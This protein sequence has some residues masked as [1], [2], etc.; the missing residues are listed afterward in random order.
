MFVQTEG[1]HWVWAQEA[2]LL[3]GLAQLHTR[4]DGAA[5]AADLL[6]AESAARDAAKS[7]PTISTPDAE[8][9]QDARSLC[10]A[11]RFQIVSGRVRADYVAERGGIHLNFGETYKTDFSVYIAPSDAK[12][13]EGGVAALEALE[14]R[15]L[16]VRGYV[17]NLNGPSIKVDHAAQIQLEPANKAGQLSGPIEPAALDN[18]CAATPAAAWMANNK[19]D[20]GEIMKSVI[21]AALIGLFA[22]G[23]CSAPAPEEPKEKKVEK[24]AP[25]YP[26]AK[27]A[28]D[29]MDQRMAA[30]DMVGLSAY[31]T[32]A[33]QTGPG[34]PRDCVAIKR[35][36]PHGEIPATAKPASLQQ[37]AGA[38]A[39]SAHCTLT[40]TDQ[41]EFVGQYMIVLP[42][43]ALEPVI[44]ECIPKGANP[45]TG[46]L[47]WKAWDKR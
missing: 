20:Q 10:Q 34:G 24:A 16:Q 45:I 27:S 21:C 17:D 33:I 14:G 38:F 18:H 6:A 1:G 8:A 30:N 12:A 15:T 35:L 22:V 44:L 23:A 36:E 32:S 4:K 43:T 47:C 46:N 41:S 39:Y 37:Y 2:L 13:W 29:A 5:S 40:A 3:E 42:A 28:R 31:L 26:P 19:P 11:Q 7:T 9:C 25:T